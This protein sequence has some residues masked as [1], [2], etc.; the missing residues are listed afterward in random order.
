MA[1]RTGE[2]DDGG[3]A[4]GIVVG[5]VVERVAID[6]GAYTEV[7]EVRGEQNGILLRLCVGTAKN[8]YGVPRFG[9]RRIFI[10]CQA[11]CYPVWQRVWQGCFLKEGAVIASRFKAKALELR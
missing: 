5:S 4:G 10:L 6:G 7:V 2:L 1:E 3:G 9:A 8:G 11:L